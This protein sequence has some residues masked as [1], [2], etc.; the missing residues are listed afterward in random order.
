MRLKCKNTERNLKH[1]MGSQKT[2]CFLGPLKNAGRDSG[3]FDANL[4][5][6][7]LPFVDMSMDVA[8]K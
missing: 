6:F 5:G 8:A 7:A 4:V 1:T 2:R 3:I